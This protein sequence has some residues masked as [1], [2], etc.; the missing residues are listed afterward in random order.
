VFSAR[1]FTPT[2]NFREVLQFCG[3]RPSVFVS[4]RPAVFEPV[5]F[6]S[7]LER[8]QIALLQPLPGPPAQAL[9][10]PRPRRDWPASFDPA[11]IRHAGGLLLVFPIDASA[12]IVL[13]VRADALGRHGGQVALPGGVVEAGESFEEAALREAH[14]E[15]GLSSDAVRV[16][17]ALTPL[18]IP[19]SGF[20]LHPIVAAAAARPALT[21]ADGE[22]ASILEVPLGELFD[23]SRKVTTTRVGEG[24]DL[25]VPAFR[26]GGV[27]IWGAT[28]MVVAEF[29]SLLGWTP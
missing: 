17:G 18:D 24:R 6:H 20:R 27:E 5:N 29:L 23:P 7:V 14:E 2:A 19:V 28:A 22:V 21:P 9:M 8:L 1:A 16:L 25:T 4:A 10:A 11:H 12:H 13:T 15:V 3:S 26:V